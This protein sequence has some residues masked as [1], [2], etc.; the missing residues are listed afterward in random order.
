M[1][2]WQERKEDL[3]M[4]NLNRRY[5]YKLNIFWNYFLDLSTEKS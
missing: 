4:L 2:E 1:G 5:Q 3:A